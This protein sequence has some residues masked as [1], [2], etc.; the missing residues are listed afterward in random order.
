MRRR[1]C[2]PPRCCRG[3][4]ARWSI[5][6]SAL[7]C[8]RPRP[9]PGPAGDP[10]QS[11]PPWT[12]FTTCGC[13]PC[14]P[15]T[16]PCRATPLGGGGFTPQEFLLPSLG[17]ASALCPRIEDSLKA[18]APAGYELDATEAHGFLTEKAWLLEQAGFGILLPAWWTRKGTKLRLAVRADVQSPKLQGGGGLSLFDLIDFNWQVSL[19]DEVLSRQELETLARLKAPL[20]KVRG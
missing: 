4:C 2:P 8:S 1:R 11:C 10:G 5:T 14:A 13:T 16:G 15:R 17:H 18:P 6:W 20:G 19:G 12:A 9:L 7:P 3:S